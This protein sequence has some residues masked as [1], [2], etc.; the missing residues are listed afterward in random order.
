GSGIH[1]WHVRQRRS[2]DAVRPDARSC[3]PSWLDRAAFLGTIG[4]GVGMG[5][6]IAG[7]DFNVD[8]PVKNWHVTGWDATI[9]NCVQSQNGCGPGGSAFGT[10]PSNPSPKRYALRPSLRSYGLHP[11]L[12]AVKALLNQFI[13]HHDG[14][15]N[16]AMCWQV[17]HNE[18]GLSCHF[19]VD[20]DGTIYQTI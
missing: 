12:E 16:S 19:L 7:V 3:H 15:A 8:A 14:C 2:R 17:L 4:H 20:N 9:E 10:P 18:R 13:F 5:I 1:Q 11:P 6:I